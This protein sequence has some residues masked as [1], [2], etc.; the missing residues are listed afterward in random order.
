MSHVYSSSSILDHEEVEITRN[1]REELQD[2]GL[3]PYRAITHYKNHQLLTKLEKDKFYDDL[4]IKKVRAVINVGNFS[5]MR[6]L[7]INITN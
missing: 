5:L 4:Y 1:Y 2:S 3:T 6:R 7:F